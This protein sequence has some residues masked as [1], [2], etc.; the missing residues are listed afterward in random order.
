MIVTD[1]NILRTKSVDT[2]VEICKR[3]FIFPLM[4]K[5]LK[6]SPHSGVGLAAIQIGEPLRA[7]IIRLDGTEVNMINPIIT[8]K[9]IFIKNSQEGCLSLPDIFVDTKRYMGINVEWTDFPSGERKEAECSGMESIIVQHEVHHMDGILIT[10]IK[11]ITAPKVG[12]NEHCPECANNGINIKYKK[13][14]KHYK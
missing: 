10:D 2:T 13:C 9:Y 4:E 8:D 1:K 6:Y 3:E 5:G 11:Y 7:C 12:R 14:K